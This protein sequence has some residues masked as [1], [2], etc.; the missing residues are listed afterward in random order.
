MKTL[1]VA[2]VRLGV[3]L[4]LTSAAI[5]GE[6]GFVEDFALTKDRAAA[7]KQLIPGTEDYY[8]YHGLHYLQ[9]E[10]FDKADA[11]TKPWLDRFG[12]TPRLTEIQ[13]RF[14]LLTY[15]RN[16]QHTLDYLRRRLNLRY[17]HQKFVP[18]GVP[19]LPTALDAKLIARGTLQADSFARWSN[20]E[21]FEDSALDW[22]AA[23]DLSP[24]RRR[25]CSSACTAP[26]CQ[27]CRSWWPTT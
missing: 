16:P 24:E 8:Y 2:P 7:L 18:G 25:N 17:D 14:A 3:L 5:A 6:V 13:T 20:L 10:Q 26:T 23:E 1:L 19:N 15:E 27:T 11:L 9:T 12:Q 4:V 21:N 22:L